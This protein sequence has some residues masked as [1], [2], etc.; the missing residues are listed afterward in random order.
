MRVKGSEMSRTTIWWIAAVL[1][2]VAAIAAFVGGQT[3]FGGAFIAVGAA[4]AIFAVTG[5][6][7][8]RGGGG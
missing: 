8:D 6:G 2:F 3:V 1:F 5:I 7:T 4:C